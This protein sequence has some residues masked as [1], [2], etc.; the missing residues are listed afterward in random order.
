[1]NFFPSKFIARHQGKLLFV[2]VWLHVSILDLFYVTYS[3]PVFFWRES[4]QLP[5]LAIHLTVALLTVGIYFL[6][7]NLLQ[8]FSK[9]KY[10]FTTVQPSLHKFS[11]AKSS[12]PVNTHSI[13]KN[14]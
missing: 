14:R 12:E 7:I 8:R 5:T 3:G 4:F 1:L 11:A 13:G 6:L 2:V 9:S 10:T